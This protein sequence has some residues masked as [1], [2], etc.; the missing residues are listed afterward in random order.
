M[1]I[2]QNL[3]QSRCLDPC[4][5]LRRQRDDCLA[6]NRNSWYGKKK[7]TGTV[8]LK[9]KGSQSTSGLGTALE[10]LSQDIRWSREVHLPLILPT[11]TF[12]QSTTRSIGLS[13]EHWWLCP[14]ASYTSVVMPSRRLQ[15]RQY[16]K[17]EL[18]YQ[19]TCPQA[20]VRYPSNLQ[21]LLR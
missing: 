16:W 18:Q 9:H 21:T 15:W 8:G 13:C 1:T 2:T 11:H 3:P 12:S 20:L 6:R 4:L 17:L 19:K 10:I 7:S 14:F 5:L